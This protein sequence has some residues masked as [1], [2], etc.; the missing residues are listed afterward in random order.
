[1]Y[2][3]PP[4]NK[5]NNKFNVAGESSFLTPGPPYIITPCGVQVFSY[6]STGY[7]NCQVARLRYSHLTRADTVKDA[8]WDIYELRSPGGGNIYFPSN[9][10]GR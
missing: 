9:S 4:E 1:M 10:E 5:N 2:K 8:K 7:T 6:S 3:L